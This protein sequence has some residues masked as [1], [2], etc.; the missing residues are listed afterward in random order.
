MSSPTPVTPIDAEP[1]KIIDRLG[2]AVVTPPQGLIDRIAASGAVV[3]TDDVSRA[4]A[5]RDW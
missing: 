4:E 1:P 5:G 2:G 3:L